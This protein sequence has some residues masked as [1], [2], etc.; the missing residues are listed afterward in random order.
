MEEKLYEQVLIEMDNGDIRTGLWAKALANSD[1]SEEKAK[2][3][4]IKYRVQSIKDEF[5]VIE[6]YFEIDAKKELEREKEQTQ[7]KIESSKPKKTKENLD[8][9][10][11]ETK[12]TN[13]LTRKISRKIDDEHYSLECFSEDSGFSIEFSEKV[14]EK[15]FYLGKKINGIW[16]IH[17]SALSKEFLEKNS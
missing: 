6:E 11:T 15:G 9:K 1:G 2:G 7:K 12:P 3:R 4:Y 10:Q 14:V 5:I 17:K 16:C 13:Y 8:I